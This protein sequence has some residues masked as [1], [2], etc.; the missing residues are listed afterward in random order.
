[1]TDPVRTCIGCG[2]KRP[3]AELVRI[4]ALDGKAKVDAAGRLSGR[5][6]YVCGRACASKALARKSLPRAL[7]GPASA[8]SSLVEQVEQRN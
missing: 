3:K 5:G 6:A 1:M 8:D 2:T 4:V 7:R